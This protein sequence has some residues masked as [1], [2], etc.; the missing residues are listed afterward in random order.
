MALAG[1]E[2]TSYD[3]GHI[4][5][6]NSARYANR[7]WC[8]P[9]SYLYEW[10]SR[11]SQCFGQF[12]HPSLW[13]FKL[14]PYDS[15]GDR[16]MALFEMQSWKDAELFPVALDSGWY[17]G[18]TSNQDNHEADWG[19]KP[20]RTGVYAESLTTE[21]VLSALRAMRTFG[22]LDRNLRL[23]F[24]AN[25]AWMG[26]TIANGR[27]QFEVLAADPDSA[28]RIQRVELVTNR[29]VVL[30]SLVP[31]NPHLVD[32]KPVTTTDSIARRYFF[33]RILERDGDLAI[34]SPIWTRVSVTPQRPV[35][36]NPGQ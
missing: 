20:R 13:S 6:F 23:E 27:L 7:F 11:D 15:I 19:N 16:K 28:D 3:Y 5:V 35:E 32:W 24:R 36:K 31:A 2:W 29:G 18:M 26:S 30:D 8:S 22:T 1:F 12:N 34:S 17:V 25:G 33:V 10:M 14:F 4:N 9:E 21:L